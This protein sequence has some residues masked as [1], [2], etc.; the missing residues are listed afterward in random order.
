MPIKFTEADGKTV[1]T[2]LNLHA[3]RTRRLHL[4][5]AGTDHTKVTITSTDRQIIHVTHITLYDSSKGIFTVDFSVGAPGNATVEAKHGSDV[6]TLPVTVV[7]PIE[8]PPIGNLTGAVVRLLLAESFSPLAFN[9]PDIRTG[10]QWMLVVL[11]NHTKDPHRFG[12]KAGDHT[13]SVRSRPTVRCRSPGSISIPTSAAINGRCSTR[14]CGSPT[15]T[16]TLVNP[17]TSIT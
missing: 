16:T 5:G 2:V 10:M 15:T 12:G 17:L 14:F 3:H 7:P 6:A 11:Q 4:S 9:Q 13:C 8:Y 1:V